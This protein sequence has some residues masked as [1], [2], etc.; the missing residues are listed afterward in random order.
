MISTSQS[1][2]ILNYA[3]ILVPFGQQL[4]LCV[5]GIFFLVYEYHHSGTSRALM[6][7]SETDETQSKN[8]NVKRKRTVPV[9]IHNSQREHS[10]KFTMPPYRES[11]KRFSPGAIRERKISSLFG[12]RG[13]GRGVGTGGGRGSEREK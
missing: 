6:A 9:G 12:K 1:N 8:V 7:V 2:W 11:Y 3:V 4:L 5:S 10:L 13:K